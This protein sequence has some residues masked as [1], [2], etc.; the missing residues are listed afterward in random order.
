MNIGTEGKI[1]TAI[2]LVMENKAS[3]AQS[4]L[5]SIPPDEGIKVGAALEI[6][7]QWLGEGDRHLSALKRLYL[8]ASQYYILAEVIGIRKDAGYAPAQQTEVRDRLFGALLDIRLAYQENGLDWPEITDWEIAPRTLD[9]TPDPLDAIP[10]EALIR[11]LVQ[12]N[13]SAVLTM[14]RYSNDP[15]AAPMVSSIERERIKLLWEQA[16]KR[17]LDQEVNERGK[18]AIQRA[19]EAM[20]GIEVASQQAREAIDR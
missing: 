17:G 3:Q 18:I 8:A 7:A 5:E 1:V 10:D 14:A 19:K 11:I 13:E 9:Q 12:S 4:V 16:V 20:A 6:V 2:R 15:T